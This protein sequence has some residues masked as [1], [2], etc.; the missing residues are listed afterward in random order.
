MNNPLL[1]SADLPAFAAIA[2]EHVTP[3]VDV[4]LAEAEGYATSPMLGFEPDK[5]KDLLRLPSHVRIPA[6]V[7]IG[8]PAEEGF[9]PHRLEIDSLVEFR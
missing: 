7:A 4:L 3:A 1:D 5:V 2:P 9:P 6:L 8:Y